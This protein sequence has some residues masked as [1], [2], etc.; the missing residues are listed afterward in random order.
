M[1]DALEWKM[2]PLE[3]IETERCYPG[4]IDDIATELWQRR[5]IKE[6]LEGEAK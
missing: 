2:K 3:I 4:L 6:Q 5:L 1:L